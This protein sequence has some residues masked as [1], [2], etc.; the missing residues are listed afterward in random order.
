MQINISKK[1]G[2]TI[3]AILIVGALLAALILNLHPTAQGEEGEHDHHAEAEA[4]DDIHRGP[5]RGKLFVKDGYGIE[6]SIYEKN[7]PPEFRVYTY[8][9]GKPL[10][11]DASKVAVTL[12]RLGRAPQQFTFTPEQ[13]YLKGNAIVEEP[14]SFKVSINAQHA[15]KAYAFNYD[16]I[17]A[18][19]SMSDAQLAQSGVEI[20]TA[21]ARTINSTLEFTG[22]ISV[23]QDRTVHIVPRLAGIVESVA[24]NAGDRVR[25]GQVLAV[26]SSALLADQR[27]ELLASQ[28]RL[29][30]ARTTYE[31]EKK[32][33]E[34]KIAPEQDYLQ[35]R[36]A[37]QE[38]EIAAQS[39][40]Q[41]LASIGGSNNATGNLTRYEIR[42]P[43]DG[44]VTEKSIAA[45]QSLKD[46][47]EIFVIAD[48]SS[49]W[50]Q[51]TIPAKDLSAIRV[52]QRATVSGFDNSASATVSYVS[53]LV[54]E[55][56]RSA[57][58]R[59]VLPNPKGEWRPG[60][61]VSVQ[62]ISGATPVKV[63]VKTEA[64]QTINDQPT[65]F[66]RYGDS[67]ESRPV[68][69][70][71]SDGHYTEIVSGLL[72]G[73]KYAAKNSFLIKADLGKS[74]ASHDH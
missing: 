41:K 54:G 65:V 55:Q 22:D 50:V 26:M 72:A 31:R 70:G 34:E 20:D 48:L 32:L 15:G 67:F 73:E 68:E 27:S 62:L 24:V 12:E 17:E 4:H 66:G 36:N 2:I 47:A 51:M 61:P 23:N 19:I 11:P 38:A 58:A 57:T 63:A 16:Q 28:K 5:H 39:A 71:R 35:A 43:I 49:L 56:S 7:V 44:T 1:Q 25:K 21:A 45:G 10:A 46:D 30:L 52:G 6:L 14:H 42:A 59:V 29:A 37:M 8:Q 53:N 13:D 9:D 64:I 18:R 69:L 74:A 40:Q 33:W 3:A 60:L